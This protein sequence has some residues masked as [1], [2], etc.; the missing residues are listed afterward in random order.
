MTAIQD[1]ST[2]E[3]TVRRSVASTAASDI[4]THLFPP[5]HGELLLW[6]IDDLLT[7][8]YLV[9][10]LLSVAPR[11]L[12]PEKFW[13]LKK[14]QQADLVWQH[15]FCDASPISEARQGVLTVLTEL[16][17]DPATRD[18]STWRAWFGRQKAEHYLDRVLDLAKIDY[19]IMTN[20]PLADG[21]AEHWLSCRPCPNRLRT[22]LRTDGLLGNFP[23]ARPQL[24]RQGCA[25]DATL[26]AETVESL[27]R[28]LAG[29]IDRLRPVYLAASLGPDW[30]YGDGSQI[31]ELLDR[32]ICPVAAE[33]NLPIALMLGVRRR[34]VPSLA[35]AGD[36]QGRSDIAALARL[37]LQHPGTKFLATVLD[38]HDQHH[39]AVT[40]RKFSNLHV[41]GC[42]WFCNTPS[43]IEEVTRMRLELL[44]TNFTLQHSDARV[45][46]QVLYKWRHTRRVAA[47]VLA[48]QYLAAHASGWRFT[49]QEIERDI[50]RLFGGAFEEFLAR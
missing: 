1:V 16:G 48:K 17:L 10:E 19:A 13:A 18:L 29:W 26:T 39:L 36:A 38:R 23:S 7:Y 30:S 24:A 9:A 40:G 45:L 27:R 50:R 21:E 25:T 6:G 22:A 20:D 49:T 44:G 41:F 2:L 46:E 5:G 28:W 33:R 4:H 42:W 43:I 47:D 32:V 31:T 3:Q 37:C 11:E 8:H 12:T 15:L 35:Q 14:Q 34:V